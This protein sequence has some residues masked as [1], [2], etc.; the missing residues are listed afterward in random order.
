[1]KKIIH[2]F[3]SF[4][5]A[6]AKRLYDPYKENEQ[7][8]E[9][10]PSIRTYLNTP[11]SSS[12]SKSDLTYKIVK[13]ADN[14]LSIVK[15]NESPNNIE[16]DEGATEKD[17]STKIDTSSKRKSLKMSV[18]KEKTKKVKSD[19][20][21][22]SEGDQPIKVYHVIR[23][24]SSDPVDSDESSKIKT[25]IIKRKSE[26]SVEPTTVTLPSSFS[27][28][29]KRRRSKSNEE[30]IISYS[31][32]LTKNL[33][34]TL[35][36]ITFS[37][38]PKRS[39]IIPKSP[40]KL[41]TASMNIS[42]CNTDKTTNPALNSSNDDIILTEDEPKENENNTNTVL[43]KSQSLLFIT[44]ATKESSKIT[45]TINCAN[46]SDSKTDS[47]ID[48]TFQSADC[49]D[50][51]DEIQRKTNPPPDAEN[52]PVSDEKEDPK[53]ADDKQSTTENDN[54]TNTDD[55]ENI[56]NSLESDDNLLIP[57]DS[58]KKEITDD[59]S[60]ANSE[61]NIE[62][63]NNSRRTVSLPISDTLDPLDLANIKTE[64]FLD[65]QD[66]VHTNGSLHDPPFN[67]ATVH[68]LPV[69]TEV[70]N[71]PR[72]NITVKDISKLKN[73]VMRRT[74]QITVR[75]FKPNGPSKFKTF[76]F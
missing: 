54:T 25:V 5:H 8:Q 26:N 45:S 49:T 24:G 10:I 69:I 29:K 71:I 1:M 52:N 62:R 13:T 33:Q 72:G 32:D 60:N 73:P 68:S 7:L 19:E 22:A 74:G 38:K 66:N 31:D 20:K 4:V 23:R 67:Q 27:S 18:E 17:I 50:N 28:S 16:M 42:T 48:E 15:K 37:K 51:L 41:E 30:R 3:G 59:C 76:F 14:N 6:P 61:R 75:A 36:P 70:V 2:K 55:T 12:P 63:N 64:P 46:V 11:V 56:Q 58:V 34:V 53:K 44:A 43:P 21:A 39:S 47:K 35:T 9:M 40:T 57:M 65:E